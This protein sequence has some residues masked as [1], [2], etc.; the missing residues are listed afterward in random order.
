[1]WVFTKHGFFSAVCARQGNGD[2][3]P[4]LSTL[5][6]SWSGRESEGTLKL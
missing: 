4:D 2:A 6:A 3:R 5:T 1:M